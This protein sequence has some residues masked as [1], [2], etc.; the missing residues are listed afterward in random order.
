MLSFYPFSTYLMHSLSYV[1]QT[2]RSES[3]LSINC[4]TIQESLQNYFKLKKPKAKNLLIL[5]QN[6]CK[7]T[8]LNGCF[9]QERVSRENRF[10]LL[11]QQI[12]VVLGVP[13]IRF[14]IYL[15]FFL[16]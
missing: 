16:Q 12:T 11:L 9:W 14:N 7:T 3:I 2:V 5:I 6:V 10:Q 4:A 1:G 13:K 8:S 15:A